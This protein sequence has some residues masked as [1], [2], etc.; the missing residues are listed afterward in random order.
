MSRDSCRS[1]GGEAR[2][3]TNCVC[4]PPHPPRVVERLPDRGHRVPRVF[5]ARNSKRGHLVSLNRINTVVIVVDRSF[6]ADDAVNTRRAIRFAL[7]HCFPSAAIG[8]RAFFSRIF[9][10]SRDGISS[11][12]AR[13]FHYIRFPR[14]RRKDGNA[15]RLP[16]PGPTPRCSR[17]LFSCQYLRGRRRIFSVIR[18]KK[19]KKTQPNLVVPTGISYSIIWTTTCPVMMNTIENTATAK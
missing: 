2:A 5:D 16:N 13:T 17:R 11:F 8:F 9:F 1:T 7:R 14:A 10:D 15:C 6:H 3:S 19:K 18:I 4:S 12:R